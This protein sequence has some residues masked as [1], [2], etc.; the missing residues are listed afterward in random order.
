MISIEEA[1]K[2]VAE[3]LPRREVETIGLSDALGR[4]IVKDV[5][6]PEPSPR[7]TNS[8]MD[9]FAARWV[10]VQPATKT[11]PVSLPIVGESGAGVPFKKKLEKGQ[12]I[13]I[14]TGAMIPEGADIVI[15]QEDTQFEKKIVKILNVSKRHQNIRFKGGEFSEAKIVLKKGTEIQSPQIGLL[16]ALGILNIAVFRKPRIAIIVTGTEIKP[17]NSKI[18]SWQI[19]DSNSAML[20][21]AVTD[22]GGKIALTKIVS[23]DPIKTQSILNEAMQKADIIIFSGGV[24]VGSHDLVKAAAEESGFQTLF[25]RV[26]QKPGKPLFVA[27]KK[28]ILIFGL[29]GNP[30]SAYMC[31]LLYVK[32]I[33]NYMLGKKRDEQVIKGKL[34]E[35]LHN[36]LSRD[37]L[38][39]VKIK[40]S[41][42]NIPWIIPLKK[43]ASHM[44][45]SLTDADGFILV[46]SSESL[47]AKSVVNV[48]LF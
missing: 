39:R 12:A 18:E 27:K 36:N 10:D 6:A 44:L 41:S 1:K 9:G 43:Q 3:N 23:D 31:Y 8:A 13:R 42:N 40:K 17:F 20:K 30:V 22:A 15:P 33:L 32:P 16:S 25:W 4:V 21:T 28:Q 11:N 37:H 14:S 45:T 19:R 5:T 38:M 2:I 24:S 35:A 47:G 46:K 26:N 7:Y 34:K 48:N 29:P